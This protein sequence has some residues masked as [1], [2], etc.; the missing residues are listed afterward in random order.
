MRVHFCHVCFV[1]LAC[2]A[3]YFF[4]YAFDCNY[5]TVIFSFM[6]HLSLIN[7]SI[8]T[9]YLKPKPIKPLSTINP[10]QIIFAVEEATVYTADERG[11][12]P[13]VLC[14]NKYS[15]KIGNIQW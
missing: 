13:F 1:V 15:M 12:E 5:G 9:N 2:G 3:A 7:C 14:Q 6:L 4:K 8:Q 11:K 10:R